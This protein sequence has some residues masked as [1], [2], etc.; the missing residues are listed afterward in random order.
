MCGCFCCEECDL[1]HEFDCYD[2]GSVCIATEGQCNGIA[3]CPNGKD[4]SVELCGRPHE[5]IHWSLCVLKH[6][7]S[8][9]R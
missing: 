8:V 9:E 1:N 7:Q 4:E 6:G 3:D 2:N 5:G